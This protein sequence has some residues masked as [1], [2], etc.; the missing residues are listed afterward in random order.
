ML[1]KPFGTT[2]AGEPFSG[3]KFTFTHF[4]QVDAVKQM[5]IEGPSTCKWLFRTDFMSFVTIE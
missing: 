1:Y 4:Y 3:V 2:A 5:Q